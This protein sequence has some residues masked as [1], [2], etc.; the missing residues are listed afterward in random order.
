MIHDSAHHHRAH[1]ALHRRAEMR[2]FDYGVFAAVFRKHPPSPERNRLHRVQSAFDKRVF[3]F[4]AVVEIEIAVIIFYA[5][6]ENKAIPALEFFREFRVFQKLRRRVFKAF[7]RETRI[8]REPI[9]RKL[10]VAR[11]NERFGREIERAQFASDPPREKRVERGV[12][13][14]FVLRQINLVLFYVPLDFV[15]RKTRIKIFSRKF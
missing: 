8:L 7:H 1:F 12:V 9:Q 10:A 2:R 3:A 15:P 5:K 6:A 4:H 13:L 11:G 14:F